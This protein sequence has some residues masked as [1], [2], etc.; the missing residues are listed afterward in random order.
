VT[1]VFLTNLVYIT[2]NAF[3]TVYLRLWDKK[4]EVRDFEQKFF[5]AGL[6]MTLIVNVAGVVMY[7]INYLS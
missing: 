3:E 7:F 4:I 5:K 1:I 2:G 6:A